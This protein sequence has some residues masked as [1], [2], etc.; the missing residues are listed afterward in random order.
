MQT[1][2]SSYIDMHEMLTQIA[3]PSMRRNRNSK[4]WPMP[5]I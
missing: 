4:G 1:P 5:A 2:P 3:D